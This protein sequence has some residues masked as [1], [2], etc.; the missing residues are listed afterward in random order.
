MIY[1]TKKLELSSKELELFF[2]F[3]GSFGYPAPNL[4]TTERQLLQHN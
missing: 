2:M 3:Q 1:N 4:T